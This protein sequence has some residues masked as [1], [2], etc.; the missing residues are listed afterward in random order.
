MSTK[1][2]LARSLFSFLP[3]PE[4]LKTTNLSALNYLRVYISR[5]MSDN[6]RIFF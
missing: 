3:R 1:L 2:I 5:E 6:G 4:F